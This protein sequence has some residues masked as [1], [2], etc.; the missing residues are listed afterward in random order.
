MEKPIPLLSTWL[1]GLLEATAL[2]PRF[3]R[4][5]VYA[6]RILHR[7]FCQK[8][9]PQ[10]VETLSHFYRVL[11]KALHSD[12]QSQAEVNEVV[13]CAAQYHLF[14]LC[15]PG[16]FVLVSPFMKA[17]EKLARR[18]SLSYHPLLSTNL[19]PRIDVTDLIV[20]SLQ[21]APS[22]SRYLL[23]RSRW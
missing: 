8:E 14:S 3:T 23:P 22:P 16:S 18:Y 9:D 5:K 1:T 10:P 2:D 12:S 21:S 19:C 11:L 4:G 7:F 20:C 15:L 13:L 6:Y 17:I